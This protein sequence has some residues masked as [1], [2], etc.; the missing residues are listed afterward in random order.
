MSLQ[1]KSE[2]HLRTIS[3]LWLFA[4]VLPADTPKPPAGLEPVFARIDSA[5]A[6]FKTFSANIRRLTH[7]DVINDDTIDSGTIKVKRTKARDTRML[8]DLTAPDPKSAAIQGKKAQI[9]YPRMQTVQEY[10]LGKYRDWLDQFYLVGFGMTSKELMEA[11]TIR[12]LGSDT[13]SGQKVSGLELI[14][15]SKE[16]LLHLKKLELWVSDKDGLPVEQ[17][18][19]PPGQHIVV[20]YSNINVNSDIPDSALKLQLPKKGI[21]WEYPQKD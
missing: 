17:K 7:T 12:P 19:F 9:Y 5:A 20:T 10:D 3:V 21:K 13:V 15:K 6:G 1:V 16:I 11:Y 8:I 14:P 4:A 2:M 18:Y